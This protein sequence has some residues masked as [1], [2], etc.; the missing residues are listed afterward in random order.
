MR[1]QANQSF[2]ANELLSEFPDSKKIAQ[3]EKQMHRYAPASISRDGGLHFDRMCCF[4][5]PLPSSP[6]L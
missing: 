6:F 1:Y 2:I 5:N 4:G 3:A